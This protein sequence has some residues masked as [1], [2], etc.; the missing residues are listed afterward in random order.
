MAVFNGIV[1]LLRGYHL[2]CGI[3]RTERIVQ[4]RSWTDH[5]LQN[6]SR[7]D[8]LEGLFRGMK[9]NVLTCKGHPYM[10]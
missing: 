9:G 7:G 5:T 10:L 4:L 2:I 3:F 1:L 8:R 6:G